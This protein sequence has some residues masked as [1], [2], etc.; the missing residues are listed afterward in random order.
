MAERTFKEYAAPEVVVGFDARRCIHAARCVNELPAVFDTNKR[1]WIQ[2]DA[3]D[4][5][6]VIAQVGRCPT[7]ALVARRPDGIVMETTPP[8]VSI[9]EVA[10]GPLYVRGDVA[11]TD[12]EGRILAEERRV[13]LCRCGASE[14]KPFCDGT[15]AKVGFTTSDRAS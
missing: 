1:P 15:H 7:G 5:D 6:T 12:P 13:A 4:A 11:I 8:E 14:N 2:P 10:N 9:Q 3:E